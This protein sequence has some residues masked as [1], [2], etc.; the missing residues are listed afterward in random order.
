MTER[1]NLNHLLWKRAGQWKI[2]PEKTMMDQARTLF[3][4]ADG[5]GRLIYINKAFNRQFGVEGGTAGASLQELIPRDM[6]VF[7][8]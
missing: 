3:W 4:L 7:F 1:D 8:F 6:A 5:G 2:M